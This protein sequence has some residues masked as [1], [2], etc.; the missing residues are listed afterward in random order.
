[1]VFAIATTVVKLSTDD[2]QLTT[3]PKCPLNVKVPALV[4]AQTEASAVTEPAT[5]TL[6][7][8]VMVAGVELAA[9][10]LPF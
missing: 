5:T 10:Q 3:V 6:R 8:T 4:P 1:M 9:A 7:P 2:S